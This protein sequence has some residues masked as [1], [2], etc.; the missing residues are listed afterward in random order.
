VPLMGIDFLG[1]PLLD[2][3]G[4]LGN[5]SRSLVPVIGA[6]PVEIP[7]RF[8]FMELEFDLAGGSVEVLNVDA[9]ASNETGP[10]VQAEIATVLVTLAGTAADGTPGEAIN[11]AV[12]TRQGTVTAFT[13][14]SG[15]LAG[16]YRIEDLGMELWQDSIDPAS[17]S[18]DVLGTLQYLGTFDGWLV[19]RDAGS[20]EFPALARE[21]IGSTRWPEVDTDAVGQTYATANGLMGGSASISSGLE[22]DDYTAAGNGGWMMVDF[23]GNL[24]AYLDNVVVPLLPERARAFVY[25]EAAGFGINNS[26]DPVYGDT[27]GYDTV[28][29][30][31]DEGCREDLDG[32]GVVG[33]SDLAQLLSVYGTAL[34]EPAYDPAAD[35]DGNGVVDLSDLAALLAVYGSSC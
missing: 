22:Q 35:F 14:A 8:S 6:T 29:I 4:D 3:D 9:T 19:L 18:A 16:V 12:D 13:G 5:G 27:I 30:A 23:D 10:G 15:E 26:F 1:G 34:G 32:D 28:I 24:G 33:L 21:R 20:G 11:P 17:S 7:G 25:L 31:V 2:L